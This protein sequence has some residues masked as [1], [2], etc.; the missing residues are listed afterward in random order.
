M[1]SHSPYSDPDVV[2]R[3]AAGTPR[4]VPGFA[5]LLRM[6]AIQLA[7]RAAEPEQARSAAAAKNLEA[8]LVSQIH[9]SAQG[10]ERFALPQFALL[11]HSVARLLFG[12]R[13]PNPLMSLELKQRTSATK[14]RLNV[15]T[16]F[17]GTSSR[18]NALPH[19][20][21]L[22]SQSL[23]S[24]HKNLISLTRARPPYRPVF[25]SSRP[26]AHQRRI[27]KNGHTFTI[28]PGVAKSNHQAR[29]S[30]R[31]TDDSLARCPARL[32]P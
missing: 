9:R 31:E 12:D 28:S 22:L 10:D 29:N 7:E 6:T 1:S 16:Q 18:V 25:A 11:S 30:A 23:A 15:A 3:Y 21:N 2:A 24:I 5:D 4:L 14:W 20:S 8:R 32:P 26:Q 13:I 27:V 17:V 19:H